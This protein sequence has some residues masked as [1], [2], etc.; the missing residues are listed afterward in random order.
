MGSPISWKTKMAKRITASVKPALLIWARESVRLSLDE[1]AQK[2][3]FSVEVIAAWESG[4]ASPS[5]PQLR[6]LGE[7]Y[8]R[9]LAVFFLSAP[10]QGFDAQ[11]EFRRLAGVRPGKESPELMLAIR[12]AAFHREAALQLMED[13]GEQPQVIDFQLHPSDPPEEAAN[14]VRQHLGVPWEI[15]VKWS[16][17]HAA[18]AG[19]RQAI[20]NQGAF[21]F[22]TGKVSLGEMRGTC[23]A[24]QPM[25]LIILNSKDAPHG[26]IFS[27]LHEYLHIL[28]H[29]GGHQTSRM[30]GKRS[31]EEQPLEVTANAVAA[32]TL[33]PRMQFLEVVSKYPRAARGDDQ[34]LRLL[35]QRVKV[36]PE[37]VLRRLVTLGKVTKNTYQQKRKEWGETIWYVKANT[38]GAVPQPTKILANEGRSF[39]RLVLTAFDRRLI[40]TSTASD[41]LGA[42]PIHFN[43]I[44]RELGPARAK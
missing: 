15:Q 43:S 20:E 19:W 22:Q 44:R 32:A 1:A 9:P 10:P 31:P 28:L 5:I 39:A 40:T 24:D 37:V 34:Q 14:R 8:K 11:K 42:K 6:K 26:R 30:V 41:Y 17:P 21:I 23:M 3:K 7:V 12:N 38:G 13:L 16:S 2:A 35:A 18:L 29:N 4:D 27:L 25:P 33:L 36:S